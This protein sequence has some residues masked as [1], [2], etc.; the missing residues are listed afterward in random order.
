[1]EGILAKAAE[2]VVYCDL[3]TPGKW[4]TGFIYLLQITV[5]DE[6]YYGLFF[7]SFFSFNDIS[8]PVQYK[9]AVM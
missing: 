1:V 6:I 2:R 7:L 4:A 3:V 5:G 8:L 9:D